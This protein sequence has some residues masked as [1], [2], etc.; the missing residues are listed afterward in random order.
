MVLSWV[1][2]HPAIGAPIVG[3]S[4]PEPPADGLAAADMNGLS[5]QLKARLDEIAHGWRAAD[6]DR[7]GQ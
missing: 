2:S 4:R 5:A 1:L 7:K 3:A 6:A